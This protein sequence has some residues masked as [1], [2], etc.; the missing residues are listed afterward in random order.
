MEDGEE[1]EIHEAQEDSVLV[2]GGTGVHINVETFQITIS[3]LRK[4]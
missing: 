4:K 3:Y 1:C 2:L